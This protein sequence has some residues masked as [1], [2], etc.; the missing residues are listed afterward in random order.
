M[1]G[2]DLLPG[3][4]KTPF[5]WRLSVFAGF[6]HASHQCLKIALEKNDIFVNA[7]VAELTKPIA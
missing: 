3:F 2:L 4:F 7:H 5:W 6:F 1:T